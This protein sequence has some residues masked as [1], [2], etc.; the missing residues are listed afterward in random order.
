L[1]NKNL[2]IIK[3]NK[4]N[5]MKCI[6]CESRNIKLIERI[7]TELFINKFIDERKCDLKSIKHIKK[8]LPCHYEIYQ[9]NCCG[10][11]I[12]K[13]MKGGTAE[14]YDIVYKF[15][16]RTGIRW[17]FGEFK[18]DNADK[19]R[20]LDIGCGDGSF[21]M[22]ANSLGI[23]AIGIDFNSTRIEIEKT[24]NDKLRNIDLKNLSDY[25]AKLKNIDIYT[26]WH[27]FEHL[28]DPVLIMK[29]LQERSKEGAKIFL[30]VPSDKFYMSN[31]SEMPILNYPPHHLTRWTPLALE[32]IGKRCGWNLVKTKYE[33]VNGAL[34]T[35]ARRMVTYTVRNKGGVFEE[36]KR[37]KTQGKISGSVLSPKNDD[38][39]VNMLGK[40]ISRFL[41]YLLLLD[42]KKY[43]GMSLYAEFRK[44]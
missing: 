16:P 29:C 44:I 6:A 24:I 33:P 4:E 32:K 37:L 28:E 34:K 27:V 14:F 8:I 20:L 10:L 18:K 25:L 15:M 7:D 38:Y 5:E 30:S 42:G 41:Y 2:K 12:S 36:I 17:E 11:T 43:T 26:M 22:Y 1:A 13:P 31:K 35:Y 19:C 39:P 9:C 3:G 21:V 23:E 40:I